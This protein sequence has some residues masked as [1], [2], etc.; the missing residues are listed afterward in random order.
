MSN[1][2]YDLKLKTGKMFVKALIMNVIF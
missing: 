1:I 2:M